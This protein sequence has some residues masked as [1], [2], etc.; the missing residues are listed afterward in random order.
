MGVR[1]KRI[2][3]AAGAV[4]L[5]LAL[6]AALFFTGVFRLNTPSRERYPVRGVD[7]SEYQGEID[8]WQLAQQDI[9][10][11]FIRAT[12]GSGY[13]DRYFSQ[14][15]QAIVETDILAGA[16]HFFS[17]DSPAET[18]AANFMAA[19]P[20]GTGMLPPVVDVELYGTYRQSPLDA[21]QVR[22][23]LDTLLALLEDHYGQ[24]P[25][26]YATQKA[27]S[28]YLAGFYLGFP[29]WIRDVFFIPTLPDGRAWTFWQYSDKGKLKGYTGE[30]Q[31][32]DLNVYAGS[33][34]E[35]RLLLS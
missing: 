28:L 7:V 26:L 17:F 22:R 34:E 14:N 1:A 23:E 19:L 10:F 27:Y 30:E 15:W 24:V 5:V 3:L 18:Q 25:I 8:W 20:A 21:A 32:I 35:L 4:L 12:E 31:Y 11:A 16:Y 13:T 9:Q 33:L 2:L 29:V 6:C